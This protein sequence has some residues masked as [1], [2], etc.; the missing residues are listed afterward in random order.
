MAQRSL[1]E[2]NETRK[3][4]ERASKFSF[5]D[6]LRQSPLKSSIHARKL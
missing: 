2:L 5:D 6:F 3:E 4:S 1:L